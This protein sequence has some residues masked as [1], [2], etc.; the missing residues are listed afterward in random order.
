MYACFS[1]SYGTLYFPG[2]SYK[3]EEK[4]KETQQVL[5]TRIYIY[6]YCIYTSTSILRGKTLTREQVQAT[7]YTYQ[8]NATY[9][10][11][12]IHWAKAVHYGTIS[13]GC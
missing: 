11:F 5:C 8:N 13:P 2:L 9:V 6:V 10:N 1:L 4:E 12:K 3:T 7:W